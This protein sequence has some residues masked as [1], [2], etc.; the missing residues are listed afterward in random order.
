MRRLRQHDE[1][2][3]VSLNDEVDHEWLGF[4]VK[5]KLEI[6]LKAELRRTLKFKS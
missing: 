6:K 4:A 3:H 1:I 2:K 5:V